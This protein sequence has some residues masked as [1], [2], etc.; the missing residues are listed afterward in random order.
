M[1]LK[2][3]A[4][5]TDT[6]IWWTKPYTAD[7]MPKLP[8]HSAPTLTAAQIPQLPKYNQCLYYARTYKA[9]MACEGQYLGNPASKA[10]A[11]VKSAV[12]HTKT[13]AKQAFKPTVVVHTKTVAA[14][15]KPVAKTSAVASKKKQK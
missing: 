9:I 1:D 10:K 4:D 6:D 12:V 5:D 14:Y 3:F 15:P 13:A 7:Q 11:A 2:L 8:H